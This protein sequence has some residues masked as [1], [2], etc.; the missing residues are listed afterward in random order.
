M[1]KLAAIKVN[2][3]EIHTGKRHAYIMWSMPYGYF[4]NNS[5]QGFVTDDGAFVN[6]E[7]A[8]KIAY[9][10]GQ[11]KEEVRELFSEQ[12]IELTEDD[13]KEA[14]KLYGEKSKLTE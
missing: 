4:K 3:G 14:R 5:V 1:I 2:N 8:A 6:R 7:E 9:K 13:I 12:L 10:N 11:I